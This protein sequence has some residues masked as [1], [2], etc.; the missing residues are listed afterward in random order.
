VAAL[1]RKP[2]IFIEHQINNWMAYINIDL[3]SI[4]SLWTKYDS[5]RSNLTVTPFISASCAKNAG[6]IE[7]V[8]LSPQ[9][10]VCGCR[11]PVHIWLADE[12]RT[13]S[14][15]GV[16]PSPSAGWAVDRQTELVFS[17]TGESDTGWLLRA[18]STD[19]FIASFYYTTS[20]LHTLSTTYVV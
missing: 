12:S 5:R 15:C 3:N 2:P 7:V 17:T 1:R 13:G 11:L 19:N 9:L 4:N 6:R 14:S 10:K 8:K 18:P 20:P 16:T